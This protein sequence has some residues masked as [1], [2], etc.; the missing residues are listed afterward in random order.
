MKKTRKNKAFTLAELLIVVAVIAVLVAVAI[1]TFANQ[2]EK[3]RQ[4]VDVATLRQAYAAGRIAEMDGY[5]VDEKDDTTKVYV[6]VLG[7]NSI[8]SGAYVYN[9]TSGRFTSKLSDGYQ[10]KAKTDKIVVDTTSL[11]DLNIVYSLRAPAT[12]KMGDGYAMTLSTRGYNAVQMATGSNTTKVMAINVTSTGIQYGYVEASEDDLKDATKT[13]SSEDF[14]KSEA[15]D[16]TKEEKPPVTGNDFSVTGPDTV[17]IESG[18][19]EADNLDF[20]ISNAEDTVTITVKSVTQDGNNASGT[21]NI[22]AGANDGTYKVTVSNL[23]DGTY[24]VEFSASDTK[25]EVTGLFFTLQI[26]EAQQV[27]EPVSVDGYILASE[28]GKLEQSAF[29]PDTHY[30]KSNET[31]T[32]ATEFDANDIYYVKASFTATEKPLASFV[33][34]TEYYTGVAGGEFEKVDTSTTTTP[35]SNEQYY[36]K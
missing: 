7:G 3:S 8:T 22:A 6:R 9:A 5:F 29:D 26:G 34:G 19:T 15:K 31:F 13:V 17:T 4:A 27:V 1:P 36:T 11:D 12:G 32:K 18:G 25:S 23:E 10:Y 2:L 35:D 20:G 30:T 21:V 16:E 14:T 28:D 24:L 33:N